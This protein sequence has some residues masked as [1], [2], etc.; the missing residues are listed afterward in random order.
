[1]SSKVSLYL[2]QRINQNARW[3]AAICIGSTLNLACG[4]SSASSKLNTAVSSQG[5]SYRYAYAMVAPTES[6]ELLYHDEK[7]RVQFEIDKGAI[8]Y[9]LKNLSNDSLAVITAHA[10]MFVNNNS[11][12]VRNE[13]TYYFEDAASGL[14]K[15]IPPQGI[16]H[17]FVIPK[18]NIYYDG[19]RWVEKELFP[20][21]DRNDAALRKTILKNL[22]AKIDL[23]LPIQVGNEQKNFT[24]SFK[25]VRLWSTHTDSA[26]TIESRFPVGPVVGRASPGNGLWLT[27]GI[28]VGLG[29]LVAYALSQPKKP[30]SDF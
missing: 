6:N 26:K 23:D 9:S 21:A 20:T 1:M 17:D 15:P 12:P 22:Y 16:V 8:K 29:L 10:A 11:S 30:A 19:S 25:I 27:A 5:R 2:L 28:V 3:I 24:F 7:I 4:S 13:R 14:P 18:D